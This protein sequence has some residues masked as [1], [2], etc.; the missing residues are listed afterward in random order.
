MGKSSHE[1][2]PLESQCCVSSHEQ[3]DSDESLSLDDLENPQN[4]F[5][6]GILSLVPTDGAQ[7]KLMN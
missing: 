3:S 7:M 1:N 2:A 4:G 5:F 6:K